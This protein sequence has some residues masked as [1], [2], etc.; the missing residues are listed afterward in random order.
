MEYK[1]FNSWFLSLPEGEQAVIR[2]EKWML[3]GRA[4]MAGRISGKASS[5]D[6][7]AEEL[8]KAALEYAEWGDGNSLEALS[9]VAIKYAKLKGE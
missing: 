1:T 6:E 2:E 4:F 5:K 7:V 3:A 9:E 8:L